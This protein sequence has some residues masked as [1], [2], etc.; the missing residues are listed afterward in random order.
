M[1]RRIQD[2][3]CSFRGLVSGS[4]LRASVGC[5]PPAD[6]WGRLAFLFSMMN[7]ADLSDVCWRQDVS[8]HLLSAL[9][10]GMRDWGLQ[11]GWAG[12]SAPGI[13]CVCMCLRVCLCWDGAGLF[14]RGQ[15]SLESLSPVSQQ[16]Q[17]EGRLVGGSGPTWSTSEL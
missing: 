1:W 12:A 13:V 16:I 8:T 14:S 7:S 4:R 9:F 5:H 10:F 17:S 2:Q 6:S 11:S 15:P 3:W